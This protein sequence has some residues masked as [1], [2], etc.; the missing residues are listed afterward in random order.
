MNIKNVLYIH[1]LYTLIICYSNNYEKLY[2]WLISNGAYI[3]KKLIPKEQSLYNRYIITGEKI[4]QKEEL[5]FIPNKLT[6]STLNDIVLDK[7]Q[8]DFMNYYSSLTREEISS[9]DYDCLVYFL[10]IDIDNNQSFFKNYY[11]YLPEIS[12]SDF[13]L[14]FTDEEK[15]ILSKIELDTQISRQDIF[16]EKALMPVKNKIIKIENGLEKFKK[17]FIYMSTRNFG[18]R[19]S[20]YDDVNT[21]VPYLDLLN[22]SNDYNSWFYYDEKRDGF[23]LFAIKDIEK[24]E[25]ITISYGK[26]N[27]IYLYTM[28]GFTIKDN[29][30]KPSISLEV[31]D[32][33][34]VI[35]EKIKI[36]EIIKVIDYFK[37]NNKKDK[38]N[39][40]IQIINSL[41]NKLNVYKKYI[42]VYQNN[43]N[44]INII[45]DLKWLVNQYILICQSLI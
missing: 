19:G 41:K 7:C 29:L 17:N 16:L 10:T 2:N 30:Y 23:V 13:P 8:K 3:S 22:H 11:N 40:I 21:L 38:T 24:N 15:N 34:F 26:L 42:E 45:E 14:Y 32:T 12:K 9:F 18:R 5:L 31:K 33:K 6:I 37:P 43:N 1:L 39:L 4:N 20:F 28:Y 25:E 44:I 35:F 27:N 36:D